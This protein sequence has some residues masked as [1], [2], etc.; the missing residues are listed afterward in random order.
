[1]THVPRIPPREDEPPEGGEEDRRE[2][3]RPWGGRAG[4]APPPH[5]ADPP[6]TPPPAWPAVDRLPPAR[7]PAFMLPGAVVAMIALITVV[8]VARSTLSYLQDLQV[9]AGSP[10][11]GRSAETFVHRG[12]PG[13]RLDV[14][15]PTR[16]FTNRVITSS[17]AR[18]GWSPSAPP[19]RPARGAA[20][21]VSLRR[22]RRC[23][24]ASTSSSTGDS[25]RL[26]RL[27]GELLLDSGSGALRV[28]RGTSA[29]ASQVARA[30][31]TPPSGASARP[32]R[33]R[34]QQDRVRL[35]A[36]WFS[37]T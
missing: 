31:T 9:L 16:S 20:L 1:M 6:G 23:R 18:S 36:L 21:S 17:P 26:S 27:C 2:R 32:W 33:T 37:S 14:R 10:S 13:R 3:R 28:E 35:M 11:S 12:Y 22:A 15:P 30:P 25:V 19:W 8:Q 34:S 24:R 5:P 4:P 29:P 7:E